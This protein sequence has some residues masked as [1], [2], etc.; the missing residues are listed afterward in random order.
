MRDTSLTYELIDFGRSRKLERFGKI[1]IDRPS[2]AAEGTTQA[3]PQTWQEAV[4]R[5][6]RTRGANGK[7]SPEEAIPKT[8]KTKFQLSKSGSQQPCRE[9]CFELHPSPFGH[10]GVL[11]GLHVWWVHILVK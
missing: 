8:W 1:V 10:V 11:A 5:Y 3:D 2:T 4:A 6:D 7:W 9:I